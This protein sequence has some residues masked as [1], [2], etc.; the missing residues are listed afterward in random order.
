[1]RLFTECLYHSGNPQMQG[2]GILKLYRTTQFLLLK[3]KSVTTSVFNGT[4]II[5]SDTLNSWIFCPGKKRSKQYIEPLGEWWKMFSSLSVQFKL[6]SYCVKSEGKM[7]EILLFSDDCGQA[8][9]VREGMRC[10]KS[11]VTWEH[12][13]LGGETERKVAQSTPISKFA[14]SGVVW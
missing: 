13:P 11:C 1:M 9:D 14:A 8:F 3:R 2:N 7:L 10:W 4:F 6:D 12:K 5:V